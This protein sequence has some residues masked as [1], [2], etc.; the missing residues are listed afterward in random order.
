MNW[1]LSWLAGVFLGTVA[2][3]DL[4]YTFAKSYST[5]YGQ[6]RWPVLNIFPSPLFLLSF[7]KIELHV[8]QVHEL[9]G[10]IAFASLFH[11]KLCNSDKMS[12]SI[13][14]NW[15]PNCYQSSHEQPSKMNEMLL[16]QVLR[17]PVF[18]FPKLSFLKCPSI[19]VISDRSCRWILLHADRMVLSWNYWCHCQSHHR[20]LFNLLSLM[21]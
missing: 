1:R 7:A 3:L 19:W 8:Q 14:H 5:C 13:A 20:L 11:I 16:L 9:S 2:L 18:P 15:D 4:I 21:S 10:R 6:T 12:G 17:I